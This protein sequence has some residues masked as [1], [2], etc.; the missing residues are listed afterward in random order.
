M[1]FINPSHQSFEFYVVG[2]GLCAYDFEC[3]ALRVLGFLACRCH[4]IVFEIACCFL[5]RMD[6]HELDAPEVLRFE[7][8]AHDTV[9]FHIKKAFGSLT[10]A[11]TRYQGNKSAISFNFV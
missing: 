1:F 7:Q 6:R 5:E 11:I 10:G 4:F 9:C 8:I 3:L 2:E